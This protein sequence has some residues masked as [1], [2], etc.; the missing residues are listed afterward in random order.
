[1]SYKKA[2]EKKIMID[3][4]AFSPERFPRVPRKMI[5]V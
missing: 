1:M 5:K 4:V 2:T 3:S